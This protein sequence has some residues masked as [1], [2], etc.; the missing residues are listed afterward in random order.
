MPNAPALFH[1]LNSQTSFKN[2]AA[3]SA[4]AVIEKQNAGKCEWKSLPCQTGLS[5][6]LFP[7]RCEDSILASFYLEIYSKIFFINIP[8]LKF[9]LSQ[10]G[11]Y[12]VH[13]VKV[14]L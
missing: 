2:S 11:F 6:T 7:F 14:K 13:F 10:H 8:V 3:A 1:R 4:K 5:L 12:Q 9:V